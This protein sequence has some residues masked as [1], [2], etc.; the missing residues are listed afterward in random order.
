MPL[1]LVRPHTLEPVQ[2]AQFA[3]VEMREREDLERLLRDR[4]SVVDDEVLIIAEEFGDFR[5]ARRRVDLLGVDHQGRLV[6]IELKRTDDGGHMELQALRYAAMLRTMTFDDV[7]HTYERHLRLHAPAAASDARTALIDWTG[8]AETEGTLSTDTRIV[9]I[10]RDFGVEVVSTVLW[11]RDYG[12]DVR[13]IRLVPY[14]HLT[15]VLLDVQPVVPVP[16]VAIVEVKFGRKAAAARTAV[17]QDRD[18]TRFIIAENGQPSTP[19]LRKR[20]A[21]LEIVQR[22]HGRGITGERLAQALPGN[23]LRRVEGE[24]DP[25]TIEAA[26]HSAHPGSDPRR[27]FLEEPLRE[28]NTAW[29]LSN[30]WGRNTAEALAK[31]VALDP[32]RLLSIQP[33][34]GEA[35]LDYPGDEVP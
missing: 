27:F 31:L 19:P 12:V 6:V 32:D 3:D 16:E 24:Y 17:R 11:L 25:D 29:V 13:C 7:V 14:K 20:R 9:L 35:D 34:S 18:L 28:A 33:V 22:L 30:G 10:S 26:F 15:D 1:W 21:V 5:D 4:F 2:T 23:K 8:E